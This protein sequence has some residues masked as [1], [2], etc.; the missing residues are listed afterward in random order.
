MTIRSRWT[1]DKRADGWACLLSLSRDRYT[2][3][4]ALPTLLLNSEYIPN[5]I[6]Y[7]LSSIRYGIY[8]IGI[9][10]WYMERP[11]LHTSGP[12]F[13]RLHTGES[14]FAHLYAQPRIYSEWD[15]SKGNGTLIGSP[16]PFILKGAS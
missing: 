16:Y 8:S 13:D 15:P 6:A 5:C 12:D 11:R 3:H 1:T 7:I 10:G 2:K 9:G 14:K 4:Y